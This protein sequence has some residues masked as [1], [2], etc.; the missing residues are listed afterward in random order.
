VLGEDAGAGVVALERIDEFLPAALV[1]V[2]VVRADVRMDVEQL[3]ARHLLAD[4][5]EPGEQSAVV[6]HGGPD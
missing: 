1:L 5:L 4:A 3:E 2:G 6:H